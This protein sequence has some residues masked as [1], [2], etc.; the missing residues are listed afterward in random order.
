MLYF[1]NNKELGSE[2]AYDRV[3]DGQ[4]RAKVKEAFNAMVQANT[5]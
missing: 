1:A 4:H 3:L 5:P 2:D